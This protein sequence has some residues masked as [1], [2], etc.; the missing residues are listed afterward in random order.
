MQSFL[1]YAQN[2]HKVVDHAIK[3]ET[4]PQSAMSLEP[5][6]YFRVASQVH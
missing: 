2:L 6:D 4:T 5:G 3:F 1:R